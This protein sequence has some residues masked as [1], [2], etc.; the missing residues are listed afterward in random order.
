MRE[1]IT[2]TVTTTV[3]TS[4]NEG[5]VSIQTIPADPNPQ[6][7]PKTTQLPEPGQE[8]TENPPAESSGEEEKKSEDM[9]P[10]EYAKWKAEK[11]R[12]A[13]EKWWEGVWVG[14]D[15]DLQ[16]LSFRLIA[17]LCRIGLDGLMSVFLFS[18]Y[19]S[20]FKGYLSEE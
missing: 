11:L 3:P 16:G 17:V 10:W 19:F 14:D 4:A 1:S 12:I 18:F 15:W 2:P 8:G 7:N 9:N 13:L 20:L 6:P 5:V